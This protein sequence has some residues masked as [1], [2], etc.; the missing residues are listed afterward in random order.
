MTQ[1][2]KGTSGPSASSSQGQHLATISHEGR[3]W[4]VYLEFAD[5]PRRPDSFRAALCYV[6]SDTDEGEAPV[7]TTEIII[8]RSYEEAMDK[9]HGME[10]HQLQS[11]LRSCLPS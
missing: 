4:E 2:P 10:E 1:G 6:P 8:E 9:A 7:R 3:F 5:D 11:L